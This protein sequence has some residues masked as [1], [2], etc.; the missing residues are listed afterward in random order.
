[1]YPPFTTR[2]CTWQYIFDRI[3]NPSDLWVLYA[4][5]GLGDYPDVKSLWQAWDKGTFVDDVGRKPALQLIDA[6]WGNLKSQET[7]R[8]RFPSWRPANNEK[9]RTSF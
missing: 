8:K 5:R 7:N 4:P 3:T 2:D 6:R 1:M 9:V